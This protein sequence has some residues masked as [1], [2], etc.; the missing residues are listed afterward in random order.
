MTSQLWDSFRAEGYDEG[1]DLVPPDAAVDF[2]AALA[3]GGRAVEFA[4][5]TGRVGLPLSRRGIEVAGIDTSTAMLAHL[6]AKPG[7]DQ[8]TIVEGDMSADRAPGQFDLAYLVFNT[9]TNLLTQP[10]QVACF[11]NA[12][13][14]LR[15]GGS[16]VIECYVPALR[17]LPPGAVAVP[18]A[19]EDEYAGFDTYDLLTQ[20]QTSHHFTVTEGRSRV[21]HSEHR[22][23]WPAEMDLM[24]QLAGLH[25]TERWADWSRSLFTADSP[26]HISVWQKPL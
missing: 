21:V 1:T 10:A 11:A 22:Y 23:A 9:I 2:L 4:I 15:P 3:P 16:F 25:L 8:I 6:R 18:F 13:R 20:R 5:G 17:L 14:H 26:S 24:A 7:A 19:V 12:A